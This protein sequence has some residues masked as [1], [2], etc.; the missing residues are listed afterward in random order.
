MHKLF[1]SCIRQ[2]LLSRDCDWVM[3]AL[4]AV[5]LTFSFQLSLLLCALTQFH[6]ISLDNL[7]VIWRR[8]QAMLCTY[9][10]QYRKIRIWTSAKRCQK[11]FLVYSIKPRERLWIDS[12]G[13][14]GNSASRRETIWPW[15][16]S[17]CNHCG[18]LTAW[19][20][21]TWKFCWQFF[22]FFLEKNDPL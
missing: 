18:V 14:N 20:R 11:C 9:V 21:K 10:M 1:T 8:N 5:L 7:A 15:I 3:P 16:F 6:I 2:Y 4:S 19:S 22:V 17:I 13:K 12:N